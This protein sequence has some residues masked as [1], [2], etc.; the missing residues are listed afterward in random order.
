MAF[1]STLLTNTLT[2]IYPAGGTNAVITTL[3][4]CNQDVA[5]Q[6]IDV[7]LVS[8]GGSPSSTNKIINQLPID[9][10]D[11]FVFNSERMVVGPGD[12]IHAKTSTGNVSVTVSYVAV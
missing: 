3:L 11:T 7:H 10:N 9:P 1:V 12:T 8:N 4:F 6:S 5:A 2:P